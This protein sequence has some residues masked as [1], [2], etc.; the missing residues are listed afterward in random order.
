MGVRL[1]PRAASERDQAV[2]PGSYIGSEQVDGFSTETSRL[3][4]VT[5]L[6]PL[7][8]LQSHHRGSITSP[9]LNAAPNLP[10]LYSPGPIPGDLHTGP[11]APTFPYGLS[12]GSSTMATSTIAASS[13]SVVSTK[14][15]SK[16]GLKQTDDTGKCLGCVN[17]LSPEGARRLISRLNSDS[18]YVGNQYGRSSQ[19]AKA[20]L[21][22]ETKAARL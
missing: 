11:L 6:A 7:Q 22:Q 5:L 1:D 3:P 2:D 20:Y 8:L 21:W 17:W 14:S 12:G 19:T 16:R 10:L 9:K 4:P 13:N 18:V 15:R